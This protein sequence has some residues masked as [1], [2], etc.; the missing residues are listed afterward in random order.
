MLPLVLEN[1]SLE[2]KIEKEN[3]LRFLNQTNINR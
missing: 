3:N 1:F 2:A